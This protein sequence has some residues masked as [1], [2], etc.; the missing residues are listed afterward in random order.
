MPLLNKYVLSQ[1]CVD[2][3]AVVRHCGSSTGT[4]IAH[5]GASM[6]TWF[7]A[8]ARARAHLGGEEEAFM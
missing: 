3:S 8:N 4:R 2:R 6:A 5:G 7:S 1:L